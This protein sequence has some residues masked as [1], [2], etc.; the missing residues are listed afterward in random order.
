MK[1]LSAFILAV[2]LCIIIPCSIAGA[3][4]PATEVDTGKIDTGLT[5][6]NTNLVYKPGKGPIGIGD[7]PALNPCGNGKRDFGEQ[8]DPS[9]DQNDPNCDLCNKVPGHYCDPSSC[10]CTC[11]ATIG[12]CT[13]FVF[14]GDGI[15][16][17]TEECDVSGCTK[18]Q[19]YQPTCD[20]T[21]PDPAKQC[22]CVH[23]PECGDGVVEASEE[24]DWNKADPAKPVVD[25]CKSTYP[26]LKTPGCSKG[27]KCEGCG[28]KK[29]DT[30]IG[31]ACDFTVP[32]DTKSAFGGV[33]C[34]GILSQ[35]LKCTDACKCPL[36]PPPTCIPT[37][38]LQ[39]N[40]TC[41][42][43]SDG[44]GKVLNCGIC[45]LPCVLKTKCAVGDCGTVSDNCGGQIDCGLCPCDM[46]NPNPLPPT[47]SNN[48]P[49]K[50]CPAGQ[51]CQA[52]KCNLP[53]QCA[54]GSECN[55]DADCK[56]PLKPPCVNCKCTGTA[57]QCNPNG[58][59]DP[60]NE[61]CD[62]QIV[63]SCKAGYQ[64]DQLTCKCT[65][66]GCAESFNAGDPAN[67]ICS[68][69][70]FCSQHSLGNNCNAGCKCESL[71]NM[72]AP[73]QPVWPYECD[74][75]AQPKVWCMGQYIWCVD[76]KCKADICGNGIVQGSEQCD[77][78]NI[79]PGNPQYQATLEK[80]CLQLLL[81]N[82][83][84]K[85]CTNCECNFEQLACQDL[86]NV[87][88]PTCSKLNPCPIGETCDLNCHCV[89]QQ[90][91]CAGKQTPQCKT[92]ADCK[93]NQFCDNTKC[94]CVDIPTVE[95]KI[96]GVE[97]Y[98]SNALE[99]PEDSCEVYAL[100]FSSND[101]AT[102]Y[103]ETNDKVRTAVPGLKFDVLAEPEQWAV[104]VC[105]VGGATIPELGNTASAE[106]LK[107]LKGAPLPD[108]PDNLLPYALIQDTG[109]KLMNQDLQKFMNFEK[110]ST[111][112]QI[113]PVMGTADAQIVKGMMVQ[114]S[115]SI[116][117]GVVPMSD[118]VVSYD[119]GNLVLNNTLEH[120]V[121]S[122]TPGQTYTISLPGEPAA[123]RVAKAIELP[124][125]TGIAV[126]VAKLRLLP[127]GA[128]YTA[129][130]G[131]K[132]EGYEELKPIE[133]RQ[134]S[135]DKII[136]EVKAKMAA[137]DVVNSSIFTGLTWEPNL[138]YQFTLVQ[139]V[140]TTSE[141]A[142]AAQTAK[143][144]TVKSA[145]VQ[146]ADSGQMASLQKFVVLGGPPSQFGMGGGCGCV[147]SGAEPSTASAIAMMLV[148]AAPM[149]GYIVW[150]LRRKK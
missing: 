70:Q 110:I 45:K 117:A 21:N 107:Q 79:L 106:I 25:N 142:A 50:G 48:P 132:I 9:C 122:V 99:I 36:P 43:I 137:G 74:D 145:K 149:S 143:A 68:T 123:Q 34:S 134:L 62:P 88:Y 6:A 67:S 98:V 44:C 128:P 95:T 41:G 66:S 56:D 42:D 120:R 146:L 51:I 49:N 52:C 63:G 101:V 89:P 113:L 57:P 2:A 118:A 33:Q 75:K 125:G 78:G 16:E 76:C 131:Y 116:P 138:N 133:Q 28:D 35:T 97:T 5:T 4:E 92:G 109:S 139:Q 85:G 12:G 93:A 37:T 91:L 147:I 105:R 69:D 102:S 47:C 104:A 84:L 80:F 54:P 150:R 64:C 23:K 30:V 24:C 1:R 86:S 129:I 26:A 15:K 20:M 71:C 59:W 61:E 40:A 141:T 119:A 111:P 108:A 72:M 13:P 38:C 14:C 144:A 17:G 32:Y 60:V 11:L 127:A 10:M 121:F 65:L 126:H 135:I 87:Q 39:A 90:N 83:I 77:M 19:N 148:F 100:T 112:L 22:K 7:I 130:E 58:I 31:E 3:A 29:W 96:P 103:K 73:P 115:E 8:C 27:C 124:S 114:L 18:T 140:Y 81:P 53:Q 46:N 55:V 82:Q 94:E 136:E